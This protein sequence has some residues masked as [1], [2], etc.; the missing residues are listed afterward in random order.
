MS[1]RITRIFP[2]RDLMIK[3]IDTTSEFYEQEYPLVMRYYGPPDRFYFRTPD[4][5]THGALE[6]DIDLEYLTQQELS[7][8]KEL[9]GADVGDTVMILENASGS[10]NHRFKMFERS[11]RITQIYPS[12]HVEFD[13]GDARM[14]RPIV[15]KLI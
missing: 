10:Y 3:V 2:Q 5:K 14:F 9:L 6:S 1:E 13:N 12:G 15:R 7:Y 11:H 8:E 4:G